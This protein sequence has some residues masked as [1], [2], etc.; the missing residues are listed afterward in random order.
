MY[1]FFIKPVSD[2]IIALLV[3][4]LSMPITVL[5]SLILAI[6]LR[7]TPFFFQQRPGLNSTPF[8]LVKFR[9][10]TNSRDN[11]GNL[12]PDNERVT[13][14]GKL[15]R[16]SSIDEL[17]QL[18]NVLKGDMSLIGPR[19]LLMEYL[20]LY[21]PMER[22]RHNVLPGITGW[23]QINGRNSISWKKKFELDVYYVENISLFMDMKI[24]LMSVKKVL[25]REGVNSTDTVTME[26]YNGNN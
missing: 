7:G 9:T 26:K 16:S 8:K 13:M 12:L 14:F 11:D 22:T 2:R 1:R 25:I 18:L 23:A 3:L 10:M 20:P 19:P 4:I 24:I 15:V 21:T 6:E 5:T 17:P